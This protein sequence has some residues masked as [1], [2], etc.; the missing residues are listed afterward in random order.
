MRKPLSYFIVRSVGSHKT[1]SSLHYKTI[2][3]AFHDNRELSGVE[4][5]D[6]LVNQ[7]GLTPD[8][9]REVIK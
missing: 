8:F 7:I 3:F 6:V 2:T 1:L 5:H 9:A 4:V